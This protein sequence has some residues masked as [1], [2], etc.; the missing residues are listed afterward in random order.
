MIWVSATLHNQMVT[1]AVI[2]TDSPIGLTVVRELGE[3]GVDVHAIGK[4]ADAIGGKSRRARHFTVRPYGPLVAWLPQF[5]ARHQIGAVMAVSERTLAELALLRGKIPNCVIIA[6]EPE[7][8]ALVL[9]KSATLAAAQD[10]GMDVP[11]SWQPG[12]AQDHRQLAGSL[13]YPAAIKWSDPVA[14]IDL[15]DAAGM[16]LEKVEYAA[17]PDALLAVL[18]KYDRL[19]LWPIVQEYIGGYGL[20]QILH[21]H[22]GAATL[23]FQHRRLREWPPSGG[24]STCCTSVPL[25]EHAAQMALSEELLRS[26][27]WEGPAMV[28]YRHD[29]G[30]GRY[31]LMEINGRFWGSMPLAYHCG[32]KFAWETW[33]CAMG[34]PSEPPPVLKKRTARYL[35][36]DSKHVIAQLQNGALPAAQ[37][38][39]L[40]ASFILQFLNPAARY[41]VWSWKDPRP[42][43]SDIW[44]IIRK[45]ARRDISVPAPGPQIPP[46][47]GI[48]P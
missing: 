43:L 13:K 24:I 11:Y 21:M 26:I 33:R 30:S 23:K 17:G 40:L 12:A 25:T 48:L 15:L 3:R 9:D 28:E 37:R 5:V 22:H 47:A 32:A 38:L 18:R 39:K 7:K 20:G 27:G 19:G 42:F 35:V 31:V 45:A 44:S 46:A 1:T 36:P 34:Q 29:P 41:Y 10:I 6:P 8:L 14:V 4:R 16:P 2:G